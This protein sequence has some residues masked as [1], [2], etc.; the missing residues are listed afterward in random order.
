MHH[1]R[2]PANDLA[3]TLDDVLPSRR[4]WAVVVHDGQHFF[5]EN[6]GRFTTAF[7]DTVVHDEISNLLAADGGSSTNPQPTQ[8]Q[9]T[10]TTSAGRQRETIYASWEVGLRPLIIFLPER[11][12]TPP[13]VEEE[14][15]DIGLRLLVDRQ[16][17]YAMW[18]TTFIVATEHASAAL[19]CTSAQFDDAVRRFVDE[20]ERRGAPV[21]VQIGT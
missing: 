9:A 5:L 19:Q 10:F 8:H 14:S 3:A 17:P 1:P 20:S 11:Y 6:V 4:E 16:T 21:P 18:V 12:P 2:T 15:R 13:D 7:K